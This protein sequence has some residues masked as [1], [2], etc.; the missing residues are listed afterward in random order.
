[1]L[2]PYNLVEIDFQRN[3]LLCISSPISSKIKAPTI[4]QRYS[5]NLKSESKV[6]H[7]PTSLHNLQHDEGGN[8]MAETEYTM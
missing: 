2:G 7:S 6:M 8:Y 5:G 4:E 3:F 1:M